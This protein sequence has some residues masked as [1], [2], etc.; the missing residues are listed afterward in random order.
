MTDLLPA[1]ELLG[2]AWLKT[3]YL[4][5]PAATSENWQRCLSAERW[6][7]RDNRFCAEPFWTGCM[8]DPDE[9]RWCLIRDSAALPGSQHR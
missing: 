3:L 6:L 4:D 1:T 9:A 8:P 2:M 7:T 5:G